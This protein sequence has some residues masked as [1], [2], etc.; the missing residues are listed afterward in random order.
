ME[1]KEPLTH[2]S[3]RQKFKSQFELVNYAIQMADQLIHSGRSPR[4]TI[5]NQNPAVIIIEEIEE[6]K[7][8]FEDIFVSDE[9][10][11]EPEELSREMENALLKSD[12]PIEKKKTRRVLA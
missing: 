7:D 4:V 8:Q 6:G 5:D 9:V 3:I 1:S 12:K 2:E 11:T 10:L